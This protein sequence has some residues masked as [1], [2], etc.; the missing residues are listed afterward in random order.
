AAALAMPQLR[1]RYSPD[2]MMRRGSLVHAAASITVAL[3]PNLWVAVPA[4]FFAGTAWLGVANSLSISA[5]LALPDWVRARGMSIYQMSLMG[6]SALGAALW[7]QVA[8]FTGVPASV[9]I[10]SCAG[11]LAMLLMRQ[12]TLHDASVDDLTPHRT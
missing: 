11:V 12:V 2:Q 6:S 9:I 8:D 10:G 7:G 1:L 4:M 3:S 5:Q